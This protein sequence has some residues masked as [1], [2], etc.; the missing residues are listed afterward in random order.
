MNVFNECKSLGIPEEEYFESLEILDGQ[1]YIEAIKSLSG[2]HPE[3][4]VLASAMEEYLDQEFKDYDS[5]FE[6]VCFQIVN[7]GEISNT[8]IQNSQNLPKRVAEHILEILELYDQIKVSK[9]MGIEDH[10]WTIHYISPELKRR[11]QNN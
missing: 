6:K 10:N 8:N 7:E 4:E 9:T 5:I 11:L 3:F 1:G 2:T